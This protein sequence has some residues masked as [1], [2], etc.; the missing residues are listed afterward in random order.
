MCG[1]GHCF[2]FLWLCVVDSTG[3]VSFV[4]MVCWLEFLYCGVSD[5]LNCVVFC[6]G[7]RLVSR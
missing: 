5:V 3:I 6:F 4:V 7:I 1:G 2:H